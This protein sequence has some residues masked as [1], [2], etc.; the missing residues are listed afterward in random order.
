MT[1]ILT[2]NSVTPIRPEI[3]M[4]RVMR[5]AVVS[6]FESPAV[7]LFKPRSA[8]QTKYAPDAESM[9]SQ[10]YSAVSAGEEDM[11]TTFV[12]AVARKVINPKKR[13]FLQIFL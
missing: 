6:S 12:T 11:V 1:P 13:G 7:F 5:I 2:E 8:M 10:R 4:L 9:L 3:I